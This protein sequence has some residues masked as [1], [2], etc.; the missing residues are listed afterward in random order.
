MFK[1]WEDDKCDYDNQYSIMEYILLVIELFI[2]YGGGIM[3]ERMKSL[4][5]VIDRGI[6]IYENYGKM[7][8][9]N[10]V[11][12]FLGYE[13]FQIVLLGRIIWN[14]FSLIGCIFDGLIVLFE[15]IFYE[16]LEKIWEYNFKDLVLDFLMRFV[17]KGVFYII[18]E[19]KSLQKV[20]V[21]VCE[22]WVDFKFYIF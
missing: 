16:Y 11:F 22:D 15:L 2:V 18:Y 13:N 20:C 21:R 5:V 10:V 6:Y 9:V 14:N 19:I 1:W 12:V 3:E 4:K 7:I 8:L 17:R